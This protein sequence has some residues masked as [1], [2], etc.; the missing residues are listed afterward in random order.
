MTSD[1][2]VKITFEKCKER[3]RIAVARP[4]DVEEAVDQEEDRMEL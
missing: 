1:Q 4:A 2:R 3:T